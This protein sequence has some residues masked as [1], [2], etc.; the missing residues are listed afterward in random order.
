MCVEFFLVLRRG[1]EDRSVDV[2]TT[3][4]VVNARDKRFSAVITQHLGHLF[5]GCSGIPEESI[6]WF[7]S[8]VR[9]DRVHEAFHVERCLA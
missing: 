2:N 9:R 7:D 1:S 5:E 4:S 8:P 6:D 3:V